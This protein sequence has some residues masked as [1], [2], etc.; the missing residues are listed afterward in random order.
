MEADDFGFDIT[1]YDVGNDDEVAEDADDDDDADEE[2][3][4]MMRDQ[5]NLCRILRRNKIYIKMILKYEIV[6]NEKVHFYYL[7][8]SRA[9]KSGCFVPRL[10]P[11]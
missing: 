11:P 9:S 8:M 5:V 1:A 10:H 4:D 7:N 2:H 3:L 6:V